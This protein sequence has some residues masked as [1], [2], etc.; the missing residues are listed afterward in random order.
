MV[1]IVS[2]QI[3]AIVLA[4]GLDSHVRQVCQ[5]FIPINTFVQFP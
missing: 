1:E 4:D 2:V 3:P 5:N